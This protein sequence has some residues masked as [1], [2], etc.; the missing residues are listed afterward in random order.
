MKHT[1]KTIIIY[2]LIFFLLASM[3]FSAVR[4]WIVANPKEKQYPTTGIVIEVN[5]DTDT[6]TVEDFNG[7]LWSFY[8]CEDWMIDDICAMLMNNCGTPETI[9][10]D[11]IITVRYCGYLK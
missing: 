4:M 1:I 3:A 6:V 2:T 7:H 10:D 11:T 9:L 5:Y 8:G